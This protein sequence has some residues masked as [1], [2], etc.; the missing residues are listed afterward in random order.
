MSQIGQ[1]LQSSS[2]VRQARTVGAPAWA[3]TWVARIVFVVGLLGIIGEALPRAARVNLLPQLIPPVAPSLTRSVPIVAGLLL[4][5]LARGLRRRKRRAWLVTVAIAALEEVAHLALDLDLVQVLLTS[6]VLVLLLA[7]GRAFTGRPDPRSHRY[8]AAVFA[9]A[10]ATAIAIGYAVILLDGDAVVGSPSALAVTQQVL[11]G[12]VGVTG[13]LRFVHTGHADFVTITLGAMGAVVVLATLATALRPAGG[14]HGL[15]EQD[16]TRLRDL[17]ADPGPHDSLGYF[18]LRREKSAIFSPSGK[19]AIGYRVIDGVSLASGDPL[20]DPEAWP[21]VIEAWLAQARRYAWAPAVLAPSE[22]G[23]AAYHRAGLDALELGDEA[24]VEVADFSL[25]GRPM[26]GV[27]QAV[28]RTRR[29]GHTVEVTLAKA[30]TDQDLAEARQAAERWREGNAERGFAMALGRLGDAHDTDNVLVRCRD[31]EGALVAL[32]SLV[33][34]GHDGLSLDLMRRLPGSDNG[35]TELMVV[36]LL[37]GGQVPGLRRVSLNFAVF[38]SAFE[39]G[40]RLGA[41]PVLRAWRAVLL[42]ASRFWQLES[43]YRANAKYQPSWYPRFLCFASPRDLPQVTVAVL[44]A[45]AFLTPPA[46]WQR[47]RRQSDRHQ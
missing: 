6:A 43:L 21:G 11:G 40:S 12:L 31:G 35:V 16:E 36:E 10:T 20:G 23:A 30:L 42:R 39:R 8:V 32:L 17:L 4:L 37:T 29:L 46:F 22:R 5:L 28:A 33:P 24:V 38:R 18:A 7:T 26:R 47:M 9:A 45:E 13:P 3:P 14:P 15:S 34:W 2:V 41:G 25:Q 1:L 44:R 19:A 27:R